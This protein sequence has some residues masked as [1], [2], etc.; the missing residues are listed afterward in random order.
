MKCLNSNVFWLRHIDIH[1]SAHDVSL[2]LLYNKFCMIVDYWIITD[3]VFL[4]ISMS[5]SKC[6]QS[7]KSDLQS[8][9][10]RFYLIFDWAGQVHN[11]DKV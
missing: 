9:F 2:G 1:F 5:L 4:L 6:Y 8:N 10:Y 11:I 7:V 3:Y